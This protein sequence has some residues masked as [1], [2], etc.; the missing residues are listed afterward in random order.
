MTTTAT[1]AP[2]IAPDPF[3]ERT[4]TPVTGGSWVDGL[5]LLLPPTDT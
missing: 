5:T 2:M 1:T 3:P 4:L